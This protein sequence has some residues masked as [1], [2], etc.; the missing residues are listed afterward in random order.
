MMVPTG[1]VITHKPVHNMK[2]KLL[3]LFLAISFEAYTQVA[4]EKTSLSSSSVILEFG[5]DKNKGI[6]LPWVI[7]SNSVD[8]A[9]AAV[10]GTFIFDTNDKKVK[11]K[12][13]SG[14]KDLS[15]QSGNAD[16]TLQENLQENPT[17]KVIIGS[18]NTIPGILVLEATDKAMV[19]PI[20]DDYTDIVNPSAGMMVY[21]KKNKRLATFNGTSW[22]FW[23]P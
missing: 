8:T 11:V 19:L 18:N 2:K 5:T 15:G 17:A 9:S 6:I 13:S 1:N 10:S 20:I 3:P 4:I 16:T 23:K 7:S 22:S 12:T 21:I 14:W